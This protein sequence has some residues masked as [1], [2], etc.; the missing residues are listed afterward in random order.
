MITTWEEC[1]EHEIGLQYLSMMIS[2]AEYS[3]PDLAWRY[4]F[5]PIMEKLVGFYCQN[6]PLENSEAYDICCKELH[7]LLNQHTKNRKKKTLEMGPP[8]NV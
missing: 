3:H 7:E 4:A 5:K 8:K 6:T 2:T 1:V